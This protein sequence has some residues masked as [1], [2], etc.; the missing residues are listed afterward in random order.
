[1]EVLLKP[2]GNNSL[3]RYYIQLEFI[4]F[5]LSL[6]TYGGLICRNNT[7]NKEK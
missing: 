5:L 4:K 2:L 7:N 3:K 1:M 6:K